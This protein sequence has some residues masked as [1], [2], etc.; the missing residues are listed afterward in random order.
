MKK[1]EGLV[2]LSNYIIGIDLGY[3]F[4]RFGFVLGSEKAFNNSDTSEFYN[5]KMK[6]L[7]DNGNINNSIQKKF[8][9][10]DIDE[11]TYL[12][13]IGTGCYKNNDNFNI[14]IIDIYRNDT[15]P[16]YKYYNITLPKINCT[17]HLGFEIYDNDTIIG[18]SHKQYYL[19]FQKYSN[20]YIPNYKIVAYDRLLDYSKPSKYKRAPENPSSNIKKIF[21]INNINNLEK[22]ILN[23]GILGSLVIISLIIISFII[24]YISKRKKYINLNNNYLIENESNLKYVEL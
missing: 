24:L 11:Y 10:V 5:E 15:K 19:D 16:S 22:N 18:F 3:Y 9:Y 14:E 13:D 20:D 17:G 23:I 2:F 8:W 4:E 1:T 7:I 21:T 6:E 12:T